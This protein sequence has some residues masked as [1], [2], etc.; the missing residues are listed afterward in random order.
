MDLI[1]YARINAPYRDGIRKKGVIQ[2]G[3]KPEK[4]ATEVKVAA[5]KP[6]ASGPAKDVKI[7]AKEVKVAAKEQKAPTAKPKPKAG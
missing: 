5:V 7:A 1:T 2:M 6:V 4:P 3:K